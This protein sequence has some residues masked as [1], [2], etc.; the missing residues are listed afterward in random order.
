MQ[1]RAMPKFLRVVDEIRTRIETGSYAAGASLP[2]FSRLA[3]EMGVSVQTIRRAVVE[4]D[5]EGLTIG[6]QGRPRMV[7]DRGL[8][9]ATRYEQ[10]A[11]QLRRRIDSGDL[12]TGARLPPEATLATDFQVSRSTVRQALKQLEAAGQ[13]IVR[14]GRRYVAGRSTAPDLAYERVALAIRKQIARRSWQPGD[15]L[16]GEADLAAEYSVSRPTIRKALTRLRDEGRVRSVPK[17]GW[18]VANGWKRRGGSR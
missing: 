13:V 9:G 11:S 8:H 2:P 10:V 15:P 17:V 3:S 5:A 12:Q 16:P 18:F 4:L 1:P 7:L 14:A 6:G